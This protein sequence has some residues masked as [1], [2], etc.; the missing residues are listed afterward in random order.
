MSKWKAWQVLIICAAYVLTALGLS[1]WAVQ[2]KLRAALEASQIKTARAAGEDYIVGV[3]T[4][5]WHLWVVV[6]P[7]LVFI[8]WWSR[9]RWRRR[10]RSTGA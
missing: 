7:P 9:E 10:I 8:G 1:L 2:G 6:I 5:S 4:P 3:A